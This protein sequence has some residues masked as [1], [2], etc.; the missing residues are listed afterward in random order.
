MKKLLT[1][2]YNNLVI[3]TFELPERDIFNYYSNIVDEYY[4]SNTNVIEELKLANN[5]LLDWYKNEVYSGAHTVYEVDEEGNKTKLNPMETLIPLIEFGIIRHINKKSFDQPLIDL[6]KIEVNI[7]FR[8]SILESESQLPESF[9]K[10][11]K[12]F[13]FPKGFDSDKLNERVNL[14]K[15]YSDNYIRTQTE[16]TESYNKQLTLLLEQAKQ[17]I[18]NNVNTQQKNIAFI[19]TCLKIDQLTDLFNQLKAE[20]NGYIS[21]NTYL[22]NWLYIFGEPL[23]DNFVFE[24]IVWNKAQN[25]LA[26][27][28]DK[29]FFDKN[30]ND[31]WKKASYFFKNAKVLK[32]AKNNYLSINQ[33]GKP[34]GAEKLDQILKD[35]TPLYCK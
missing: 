18:L 34:K 8:N 25:L 31:V 30:P 20:K 3:K 14:I 9:R 4:E 27:F 2:D 10:E 13:P 33:T 26:Y 21:S 17:N 16:I 32:Q 1:Q 6:N 7:K 22:E 24:L 12:E 5:R 11:L 23:P 19:N 35:F 29:L 15:Q 28:I